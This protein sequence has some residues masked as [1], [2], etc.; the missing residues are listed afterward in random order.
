MS[1]VV[2]TLEKSVV[3]AVSV[4][5]D[6]R[7]HVARLEKELASHRDELRRGADAPPLPLRDPEAAVELERLRG[8]RV[9]IRE[10][11]RELLKEI[12]QVNR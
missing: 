11:I 6:L 8:E 3:A 10:R 7:N 2:D 1:N 4:I 9:E 12:D 5:A